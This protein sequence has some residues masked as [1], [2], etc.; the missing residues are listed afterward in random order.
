MDL[1]TLREEGRRVTPPTTAAARSR[2]LFGDINPAA[3]VVP[4]LIIVL[5][6]VGHHL[7]DRF[8]TL[9]NFSNLFG[10]VTFLAF[11]ALGQTFVISS[12]DIDLSIGSTIAICARIHQRLHQSDP[13]DVPNAGVRR[14]HRLGNAT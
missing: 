3:I 6:L 4:V 14:R 13:N 11:V 8:G 2:R 12:R 7:S 1:G 9:R 10:Q 5:A